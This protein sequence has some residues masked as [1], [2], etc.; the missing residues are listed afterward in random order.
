M[1]T[2]ISQIQEAK[3][4]PKQENYME[5]GRESSCD[6]YIYQSSHHNVPIKNLTGL[7]VHYTSVKLRGKKI[8]RRRKLSGGT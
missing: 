5:C 2:I 8:K 4:S 7:V 1:K 6:V 3:E